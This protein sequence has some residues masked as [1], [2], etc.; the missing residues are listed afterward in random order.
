MSTIEL[1]NITKCF[2]KGT[3]PAVDNLSV[4]VSDRECLVLVGP[5]G[6]GKTTILRIIAGLTDSTTGELLMDGKNMAGVPPRNREI[7]FVFQNPALYPHMTVF[8]N[9]AYGLNRQNKGIK[10][11]NDEIR[12]K[13]ENMAEILD[14]AA[15]LQQKPGELSGGQMQRV[16]IGR[17]IVREPRVLL[18]DE[19]LAH[20]DPQLRIQLRA[21]L[22]A[23]RNRIDTTCI[24]VTHDQTE[25]MT[26]G[27]RILVMKDGKM[28]QL[29]TALSIYSQP[30]T[31]F[32]AAFFGNPGMNLFNSKALEKMV[33]NERER[34]LDQGYFLYEGKAAILKEKQHNPDDVI[35]GLRPEHIKIE[36]EPQKG[37]CGVVEATEWLGTETLIHVKVGDTRL[38][39]RTC[40]QQRFPNNSTIRFSF[41]L[42]DVY[43]YHQKSK[44]RL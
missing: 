38:C 8:D 6:C 35:I 25:A 14:V 5:S 1:K 41:E 36:T 21:E 9:M 12:K 13:I 19:P 24:Y 3:K 40:S 28:E 34:F 15:C 23:L 26:L 30:E 11:T 37:M 20:L 18:M 10:K 32:V 44:R 4:T 7:G 16:A 29:G 42:K 43:L 22:V 33:V 17:A 31:S 2:N 27:D 39:I